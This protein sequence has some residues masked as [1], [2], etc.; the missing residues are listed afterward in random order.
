MR[1]RET[2]SAGHKG[3]GAIQDKA[4]D[5]QKNLIRQ[6]GEGVGPGA[7]AEIV[8]Q[9]ALRHD[10]GIPV[11]ALFRLLAGGFGDAFVC[12]FEVFPR[13]SETFPIG[14]QAPSSNFGASI[15]GWAA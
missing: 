13:K 3:W 9:L 10:G 1:R 8:G 12:F 7:V 11:C 14:L 2:R 5:E 6:A 15:N 4:K